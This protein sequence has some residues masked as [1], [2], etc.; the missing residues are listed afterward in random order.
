ME[1]QEGR[2]L[3]SPAGVEP[4]PAYKNIKIQYEVSLETGG[5]QA[6]FTFIRED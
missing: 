3:A 4:D 2:D 1:R 5:A 6:H